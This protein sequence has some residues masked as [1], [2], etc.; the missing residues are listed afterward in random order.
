MDAPAVMPK[1]FDASTGTTLCSMQWPLAPQA[2]D[3]QSTLTT[4]T[5]PSPQAGQLP[6]QSTSLSLPLRMKSSQLVVTGVM[7]MPPE[8]TCER[9]SPSPRQARLLTHAAQLPPQS[10]SVS[11]PS[12]TPSSQLLTAPPQPAP[13]ISSPRSPIQANRCM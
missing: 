4:Q 8:Q 11:L 13:P 9:Q 6:P 3:A 7:Q 10:M 12:M 5:R 1:T 2:P